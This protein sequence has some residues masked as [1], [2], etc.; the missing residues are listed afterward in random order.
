MADRGHTG[1]EGRLTKA[2]GM[3]G[4]IAGLGWLVVAYVVSGALSALILPVVLIAAGVVTFFVGRSVAR[5]HAL[6]RG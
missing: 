2:C 6:G 4:A 3:L 5:A 1:T